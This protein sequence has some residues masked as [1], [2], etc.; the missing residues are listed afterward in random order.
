MTKQ[1]MQ[2][3]LFLAVWLVLIIESAVTGTALVLQAMTAM[4]I[5]FLLSRD[6]RPVFDK[7]NDPRIQRLEQTVKN[8]AEIIG[9]FQRLADQETNRA[10]KNYDAF[11]EAHNGPRPGKEL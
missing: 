4:G 5:T 3:W 6:S 1:R 7:A 9:H 11:V 2:F 10:N 8:Q